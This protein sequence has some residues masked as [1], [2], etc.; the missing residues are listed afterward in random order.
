VRFYTTSWQTGAQSVSV[1]RVRP[2]TQR[3]PIRVRGDDEFGFG[4]SY[5]LVAQA[6]NGAVVGDYDREIFVEEDDPAPTMTAAPLDD[7]V[8]EGG[9][10]SWRI[11]LSEPVSQAVYPFLTFLPPAPGP[12]LSTTDL[13]PA[14]VYD[15]L[16]VDPEP[17]RPLSAAEALFSATIEPGT[18]QADVTIPT[19]RDGVPE[20]AERVRMRL[21]A[22]GEP[23][24][25]TLPELTGVVRD[26]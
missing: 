2:G 19:A 7:D 16:F 26:G 9:T 22:L 11:T 21:E 5:G 25:P 6:V 10:L 8:T 15:N 17:S 20:G 18:T 1:V 12:E 13:P 3:V 23:A 4:T 14:W 24:P